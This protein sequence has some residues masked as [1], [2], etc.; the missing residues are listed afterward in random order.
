LDQR[1]PTLLGAVGLP[2][3]DPADF[4]SPGRFADGGRFRFEIP[5]VEGPAA[6]E[7]VLEEAQRL[8]APL[9]RISQGSGVE[10]LTDAE[11]RAM[12]AMGRDAGVEVSLF[13]AP[14]AIYDTGAMHLAPGGAVVRNRIRGMR[15]M[16]YAL[17]EL[18]RGYDLGIRSFLVTDIGLLAVVGELRRQ[19]RLPADLKVKVSVMMGEANA[20]SARLLE[21]LGADTFNIPADLS[22]E[23]MA[24]MR[25]AAAL[26][27]DVYVESPDDVGGFVRYHEIPR[28]VAAASPVYLK[29]GLRNAPGIYPSG[30]HLEAVAVATARAR[31]QRLRVGWETIQRAGLADGMSP[32]PVRTDDLALPV[33]SA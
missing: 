21:R 12:A 4:A 18:M 28:I 15:Q 29:F 32:L 11:V 6:L 16:A 8:D 26:P 1:G 17:D 3:D 31:A 7:A 19:G 33:P 2:A 13:I 22:P 5:S 25:Q 14:R 23:Q 24:S 9:H 20:A 30:R 27:L 10:L